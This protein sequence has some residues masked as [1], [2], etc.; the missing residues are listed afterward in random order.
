[1]IIELFGLP[2][3]G[4]TTW[5]NYIKDRSTGTKYQIIGTD[6]Y[7]ASISKANVLL[8]ILSKLGF[9][10][11][12]KSF[13]ILFHHKLLFNKK[14]VIN[15][16]RI[17]SYFRFYTQTTRKDNIIIMDEA[18]VQSVVTAIYGHCRLSQ[19]EFTGLIRPIV[20][21]YRISLYYLWCSVEQADINISKRA[22]PAHGRCDRILDQA[23]RYSV[24]N[25][26]FENF[27]LIIESD[28]PVVVLLNENDR[29]KHA[30]LIA[31]MI[32]NK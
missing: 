27:N 24:L 32:E 7:L 2:G 29:Q 28:I 15:F 12:L 22:N 6:Q 13:K 20:T 30:D 23:L 5:L 31:K 11:V 9:I 19:E 8:G 18:V 21:N 25:S 17:P 3:C 1:M 16:L 10:F 26:E 4:K 14:V